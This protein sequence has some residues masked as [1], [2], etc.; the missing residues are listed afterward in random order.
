[1]IDEVMYSFMSTV[2]GL[3][4]G[5]NC[6]RAKLSW[7]LLYRIRV[8]QNFM[9]DVRQADKIFGD[10]QGWRRSPMMPI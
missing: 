1:M 4:R 10:K 6:R 7:H 2:L 9:M 3:S 8:A 5:V